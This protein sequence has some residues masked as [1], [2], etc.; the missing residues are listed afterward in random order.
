MLLQHREEDRGA[1]ADDPRAQLSWLSRRLSG[2]SLAWL[3]DGLVVIAALL[4]FAFIFLSIAHELPPWPLTLGAASAAAVFLA[5]TY[6][7]VFA[8]FGGSSLGARLAQ[9]ASSLEEESED[10][11]RFR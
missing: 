9:A 7:A 2:R 10:A 6:R 4:L 3:V 11:G 8:V 1:P 5:A